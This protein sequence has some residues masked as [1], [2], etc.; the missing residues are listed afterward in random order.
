MQKLLALASVLAAATG[1]APAIAHEFWLEPLQFQLD[2]GDRLVANTL[3]GQKLDGEILGYYPDSTVAFD[4]THGDVVLP[5]TGEYEQVPAADV[6]LLGDG[7]HVLRFQSVSYQLTYDTLADFAKFV[8]EW[9][10]DGALEQHAAEGFANEDIREVYFRYAKALID[11]GDGAGQDRAFGMPLE[12]VALNNPYEGP[13]TVELELRFLGEPRAGASVKVFRR[14]PD[15]EVSVT[16]GRT[17]PDGRI[18]VPAEPGFFLVNAVHLELAS[19]R[20]EEILGA[21]WQSLWAS[22]TYALE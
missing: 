8:G 4:L 10:L 2:P 12:W 18:R 11:V 22:T 16:N 13:E 14:A 15:G 1:P 5:V 19:P 17:G 3:V 9:R 6:R 20:M 21:S 7:L